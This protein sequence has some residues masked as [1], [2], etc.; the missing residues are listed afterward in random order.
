MCMFLTP[1]RTLT[2]HSCTQTFNRVA[3]T[4]SFGLLLL[5][6]MC[7]TYPMVSAHI[8]AYIRAHIHAS[9]GLLLLASMFLTYPMVSAHIHAHIRTRQVLDVTHEQELPTSSLD[10]SR[11]V[12]VAMLVTYGLYLIFQLGT[13]SLT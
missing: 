13:V 4:A 8:H 5:S 7:L 11:A 1:P 10:V 6:T 2:S 12:S 9:C 3:T